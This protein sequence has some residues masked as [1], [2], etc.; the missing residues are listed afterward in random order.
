[1]F[2]LALLAVS[3]SLTFQI[4]LP[5][6]PV[7]VERA[8]PHGI[9]GAATAALFLG[10]VTGELS[11]PWLMTRWRG[12]G[13][14]VGGQLVTAFS[15]LIYL[16]PH[17][18]TAEMIGAAALRGVGMG[19]AIV[20]AT[21]LVAE[22]AQPGRRGAT[23]GYFGLALTVPGVFVPSIGVFVLAAGHPE[24]DA[25]IAFVFALV[26]AF[27]S[28]RVPER[29]AHSTEGATNLL[30]AIRRPGLAAVFGAFVLA[31]C[32]FGGI[33]TFVPV[34]LPL[35][36][37]GSAA[38][39]LLVSGATRALSRWLAG[40]LV[41]R[42]PAR[43]VL[44]GGMLV[45]LCGLVALALHTNAPVVI[46]AGLAYGTGYGALQTAAY[47]AMLER[48]T[49]RDS[50]AISALWNS[51]IDLGASLGGILIGLTAAQLGYGAAAWVLPGA[52][53][54][55]LPLFL[56]PGRPGK[57]VSGTKPPEPVALEG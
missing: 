8:G 31:S 1:V 19:V 55:S 23:I 16:V 24:I 20:I 53:L 7:M 54:L 10:A 18:T 37:L 2:L 38:T 3:I 34:A 57:A 5:V 33:L 42:V 6:V 32:S 9:A 35:R 36:G 52:V 48:G 56:L 39:Y 50:G 13:L 44:V 49:A 17:A 46:F 27:A 15:S 45:S 12:R 22:L 11:S 21:A 26:G 14:L 4:L 43:R 30:G 29:S 41:D 25:L 47:V 28:L 40:L 51:G